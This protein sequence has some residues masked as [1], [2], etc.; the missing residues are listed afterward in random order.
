LPE[1]QEDDRLDREE[2]DHRSKGP[3]KIVGGEVE[4]EESVQGDGDAH[5]VDEGG[6]QVALVW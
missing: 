6:V 1:R 2:L 3:K 4:E 5:V